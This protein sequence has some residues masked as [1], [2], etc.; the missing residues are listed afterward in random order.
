[1]RLS[2]FLVWLAVLVFAASAFAQK[3]VIQTVQNAASQAAGLP[4]LVAPQM[5]V[6]IRGENLASSAVSANSPPLPTILGGTLVLVNGIAAPL[7]YVSPKQLN[8]QVP[9]AVN[10]GANASIVVT[11][12]AGS[13]DPVSVLWLIGLSAF[14]RR[15]PVAAATLWHTTFTLTLASA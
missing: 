2:L 8:L 3:P 6:T 13:S 5:L 10:G 11:T 4:W 12:A 14:S 1:M 15:T 9:G 7:F